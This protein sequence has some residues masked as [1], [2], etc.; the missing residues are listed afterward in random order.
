MVEAVAS[1]PWLDALG[2]YLAA[3]LATG[4]VTVAGGWYA[5]RRRRNGQA[6]RTEE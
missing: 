2:N 4:T 6:D 1:F 3:V 5:R